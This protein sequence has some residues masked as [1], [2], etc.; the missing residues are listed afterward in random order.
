VLDDNRISHHQ[1]ELLARPENHLRP[2]RVRE[3]W[4]PPGAEDEDAPA[5]RRSVPHR[6]LKSARRGWSRPLS[7]IR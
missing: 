5:V 4:K 1:R 7:R 6:R 2:V 3:R